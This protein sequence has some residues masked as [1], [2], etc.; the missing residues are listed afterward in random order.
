M[1]VL[2]EE[3]TRDSSNDG[4]VVVIVEPGKD[5]E[6]LLDIVVSI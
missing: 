5:E 3:E 2:V 6:D 1:V 4:T